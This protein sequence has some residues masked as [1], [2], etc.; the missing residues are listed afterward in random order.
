MDTSPEAEN[1]EVTYTVIVRGVPKAFGSLIA[2][3]TSA[4]AR[5]LEGESD[6]A[7]AVSGFTETVRQQR[8]VA[9]IAR[10]EEILAGKGKT[11]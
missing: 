3:A 11:L 8:E 2:A 5:I 1:P 7:Y 9:L 6:I 4:A 10:I